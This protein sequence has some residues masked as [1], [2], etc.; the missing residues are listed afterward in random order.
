MD[1]VNGTGGC[2]GGEWAGELRDDAIRS[3]PVVTGDVAG[4]LLFI[5]GLMVAIP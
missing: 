3:L 5:R 1:V 2:M 4:L